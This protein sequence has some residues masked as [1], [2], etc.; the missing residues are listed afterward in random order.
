MRNEEEENEVGE[1][2]N[3][4]Q[5]RGTSRKNKR[6]IRKKVEADIGEEIIRSQEEKEKKKKRK[7]KKEEKTRPYTR[8]LLSRAVG[9]GQ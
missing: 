9:Q 5:R 6:E 7:K 4:S 3:E 8:L 2:K 1:T